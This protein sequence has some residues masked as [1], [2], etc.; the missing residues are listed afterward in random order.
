MSCRRDPRV[1]PWAAAIAIVAGA[2]AGCAAASTGDGVSPATGAGGGGGCQTSACVTPLATSSKWSIEIDPLGNAPAALTEIFNMNVGG[3]PLSRSLSLQA[4]SLTAVVATFTSGA[5]SPIPT[6]AN[7]VLTLPSLIPGRPDLIFEAAGASDPSSGTIRGSLQ[8]PS[9]RIAPTTATTPATAILQLLPLSP[10]DQQS[11]PASFSVTVADTFAEILPTNTLPISGSLLPAIGTLPTFVARAFQSG[12][13]IS[14]APLTAADGSFQLLLA[15]EAAGGLV[16]VEL[17]P[18]NQGGPDPWYASN[19]IDPTTN[20]NLAPI[21]LPAYSSPNAFTLSVVGADDPTVAVSGAFV[22]ALTILGSNPSGTTDFLRAGM[23]AANGA[24]TLSLSPGTLMTARDY[25]LTVIPPATSPYATKCI[26]AVGV[27]FGGAAN[28]PVSL[29]TIA[30]ARRPVL[31]G[32]VTDASGSPVAQVAITATAGTETTGGCANTSAVSAST[33]TYLD[34]SFSLPLD[35]G[36][37]QLDYDPPAGSPA[38]RWTELGVMVATGVGRLEHSVALPPGALIEG[39][40]T[41]PDGSRLPSATVRFFDPPCS[42]TNDC[43]GSTSTPPWL[44]GQT[45]TD[46]NGMFRVVVPVPVPGS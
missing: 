6:A 12:T 46:A 18:Q 3:A 14:N 10:A 28:A 8:L 21:T 39:T 13:Q 45:A 1:L 15:P 31:A 37:Y 25:D 33:T 20:R 32:K 40:V 27:T 4:D 22:R 26:S 42:A 16:T 44:R 41:A 11:P 19:P 17:T 38:P 24:V 34:G 2:I 36:T 29:L 9:G 30:L 35:S 7:V 5:G 43:S 23:T